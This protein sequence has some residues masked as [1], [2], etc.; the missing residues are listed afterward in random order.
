[1]DTCINPNEIAAGELLAYV[2]GAAPERVVQHVARCAH[3]AAL[4]REYAH[5]QQVLRGVMYRAACPEPEVLGKFYLRELGI[6]E[7]LRVARHLRQCPHCRAEL[8]RYKL[9][10]DERNAVPGLWAQLQNAVTEIM[11][12]T[13]LTPQWQLASVRGPY[14]RQEYQVGATKIVLEKQPQ[15]YGRVKLVGKVK[16]PENEREMWKGH[17]VY[18][19]AAARAIAQSHI[20]ARGFF[21]LEHLPPG[22]YELRVDLPGQEIWLG[23]I[24]T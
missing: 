2:D 5:T 20:N 13:Q 10:P 7:R 16:A 22:K 18:L 3:C 23:N 6:R 11:E 4:A 17:A 15:G 14:A 19:Y 9:S 1:M 8:A 21:F 24:E 12:A